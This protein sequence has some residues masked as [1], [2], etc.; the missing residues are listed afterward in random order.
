MSTL[1]VA[2][3]QDTS[4]NNSSTPEQ[5]AEGRAKAWANFNGNNTPAFRDD[6]NFSS[7]TDNGVGYYS[8]NFTSNMSDANY[9]VVVGTRSRPAGNVYHQITT[10]HA[11]STSQVQI[12]HQQIEGSS[13]GISMADTDTMHVCVFGD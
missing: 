3:I 8:L 12:T 11:Q 1:K 13:N 9:C 7:I 6:F 2:T 5:V 4:G 10:V